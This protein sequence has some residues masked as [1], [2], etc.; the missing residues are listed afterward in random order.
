MGH[1][2]GGLD[3]QVIAGMDDMAGF[4]PDSECLGDLFN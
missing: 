1:D 4:K 3:R 2:M